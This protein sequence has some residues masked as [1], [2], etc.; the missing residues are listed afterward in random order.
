MR[1]GTD[2]RCGLTMTNQ[3]PQP[4]QDTLSLEAHLMDRREV[5]LFELRKIEKQL[6]IKPTIRA[7]CPSC[8]RERNKAA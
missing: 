7:M 1:D 3:P 8:G 5:L 2:T 4:I 6:G